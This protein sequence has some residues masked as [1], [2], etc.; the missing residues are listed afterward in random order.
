MSYLRRIAVATCLL[1]AGSGWAAESAPVKLIPGTPVEFEVADAPRSFACIRRS[2]ETQS[3]RMSIKLPAGYT[4]EKSYPLLVFLSGGDGGWGGELHQAD[5]FLGGQGYVLCNL[6][7]FKRD[8]GGK[9]DDQQ[10]TITPLEADHALPAFRL[11]LNRLRELVPNLD[12]AR[13]VLAGF[14]NGGHSAALL[15]AYGDEDLLSRFSTFVLIEGGFLL[16]AERSEIWPETRFK[17][18][19]LARLRA[20]RVLLAYGDQREPPDRVPYIADAHRAADALSQA[21]VKT[22][23]LPMKDTGHDFPA[24][25]ME[26]AR[27]WVLSGR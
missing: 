24:T 7:L 22:F 19:D 6:P 4:K 1:A 10:W 15:M 12:P 2:N 14:S 17:S 23:L 8:F 13:S 11:L 27:E 21:G 3:V 9:T 25:A 26:R 18:A 5:P 16:G 20:K